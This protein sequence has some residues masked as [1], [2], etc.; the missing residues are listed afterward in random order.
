MSIHFDEQVLA[1]VFNTDQGKKAF[2]IIVK[3]AEIKPDYDNANLM[4]GKVHTH[5]FVKKLKKKI[6][7]GSSNHETKQDRAKRQS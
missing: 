4:Y 1:S 5:E 3:L 6:E 2:D 7:R